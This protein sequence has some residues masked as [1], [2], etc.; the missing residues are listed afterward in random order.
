MF[1]LCFYVYPRAFCSMEEVTDMINNSL[2]EI[3]VRLLREQPRFQGLYACGGD[4]T[5]ALCGHFG[6]AGLDL[7]DEVLPL[8]AYGQFSGGEFDGLDFITKG[9]S[10]GDKTALNVCV[11]YLKEKLFI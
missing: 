4:V 6:A 7:R 8:A 5:Q 2:A 10:Q 9:G 3:T 11:N 1:L